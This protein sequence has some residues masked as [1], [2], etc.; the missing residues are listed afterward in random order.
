M[1]EFEDRL[2]AAMA[3]AAG[4]PPAGPLDGIRLRHRRHVRRVT[5]ACVAVVAFGLA[6]TLVSRGVLASP[7]R[8]GPPWPR[9]RPGQH[10]SGQHGPGQHGPG[11]HGPACHRH[12]EHGQAGHGGAGHRAPGLPVR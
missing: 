9:R 4:P 3:A 8:G 7:G 11:Q 12:A 2:R 10:S 1:T 6:G 5:A